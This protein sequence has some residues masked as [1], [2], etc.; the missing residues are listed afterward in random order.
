MLTIFLKKQQKKIN[1]FKLFNKLE[2][3]TFTT[4]LEICLL[5]KNVLCFDGFLQLQQTLFNN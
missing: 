4:F 3:N 2:K 5:G 1:V